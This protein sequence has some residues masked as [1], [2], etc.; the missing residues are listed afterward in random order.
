MVHR[1]VRHVG[2]LRSYQRRHS[3]VYIS[4]FVPKIFAVKVVAKLHS[5]QVARSS[6]NVEIGSLWP[7]FLGEETPQ[8]LDMHFIIWFTS[9]HVANFG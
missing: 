7:R 3:I 6:K 9:E 4:C 5:R 1:T 2:D 8:I